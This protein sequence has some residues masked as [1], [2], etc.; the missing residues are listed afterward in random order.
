MAI[1]YV[2]RPA[3][4][5]T[6]I[7]WAGQYQ[8][9]GYADETLDDQSSAELQ[10][11]LNPPPTP[12]QLFAS[13]LQDGL[14]VT[15]TGTPA[16]SA[17]YALDQTTLSEIQAVANDFAIGFG[18]P[19]DWVG[20]PDINGVPKPINGPATVAIYKAMRDLVAR[21]RTTQA[22]LE[23]GQPAVWPSQAVTIA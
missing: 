17:T 7:S 2:H 10:A 1:W 14:A 13:K 19:A 4:P 6:A 18:L 8:Q 16:I 9:P 15:S 3:G 20:Y 5:G 11:F 23:A 21:M 22:T 12:G